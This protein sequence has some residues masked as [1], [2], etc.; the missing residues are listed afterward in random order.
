MSSPHRVE[1]AASQRTL[2]AHAQRVATVS[3]EERL[4]GSIYL[5]PRAAAGQPPAALPGTAHGRL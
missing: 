3:P 1:V 5:K 4:E 2:P